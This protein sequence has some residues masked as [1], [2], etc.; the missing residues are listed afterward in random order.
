MTS[1][2]RRYVEVLISVWLSKGIVF[3]Q[4]NAA[5][6]KVAIKHQKLADLHFEV[7]KHPAYSPDLAPSYYYLFPNLFIKPK[8]YQTPS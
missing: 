6:H 1:Y 2:P 4:D 5:S 3:L 8:T 7:L